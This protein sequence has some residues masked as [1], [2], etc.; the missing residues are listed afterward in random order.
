MSD[1]WPVVAVIATFIPLVLLERWIH[2]H[3]HG[4]ALL[5]TRR[6]LYF[7]ELFLPDSTRAEIILSFL[8]LL[9]LVRLKVLRIG[10]LGAT[11]PILCRVTEDFDHTGDWK[12][13]LVDSLLNVE[14]PMEP[15]SAAKPGAA[16]EAA[17][18][19]VPEEGEPPPEHLN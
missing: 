17:S 15:V 19:P 11:G 14:G 8:S 2:Q 16:E 3:I 9:E 10:Q 5:A 13:R 18:E 6:E 12:Q 4:V 1:W 7:H